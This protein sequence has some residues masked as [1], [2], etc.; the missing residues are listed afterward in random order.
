MKNFNRQA[1]SLQLIALL[2]LVPALP[3]MAQ[4][5][6]AQGGTSAVPKIQFEEYT[7]PNGLQVI[8][9]IDRKLPV[10]HVNQWFHVGSK[11]ERAGRSGFAHL[12]DYA[13]R[14]GEFSREQLEAGE[15]SRCLCRRYYAGRG[16]GACA[17]EF[18]QLDRRSGEDR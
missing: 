13:R 4:T 15:F 11:N 9:H 17:A 2:L 12:F 8:L 16:N 14:S 1:L 6:V 18:W 10:V 7:L 5:Q 3:V